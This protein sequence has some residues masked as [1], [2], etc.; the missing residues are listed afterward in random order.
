NWDDVPGSANKALADAKWKV[1]PAG[2]PATLKAAWAAVEVGNPAAAATAV[3]KG[4]NSPKPDIQA[5]S[6]KLHEAVQTEAQES[7]TLAEQWLRGKE[8][9]AGNKGECA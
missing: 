2:I 7:L 6:A 8:P 5:A 9:P 1:D 3:K 4:L